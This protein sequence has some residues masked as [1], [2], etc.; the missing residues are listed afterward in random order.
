MENHARR[1]LSVPRCGAV[2]AARDF[3]EEKG[4]GRGTSLREAGA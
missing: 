4:D 2:R 1:P 3:S